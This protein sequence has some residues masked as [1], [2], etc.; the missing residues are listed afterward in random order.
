MTKFFSIELPDDTV[1]TLKEQLNL[2]TDHE[3]GELLRRAVLEHLITNP[4]VPT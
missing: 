1:E 3:V 2:N 4:S